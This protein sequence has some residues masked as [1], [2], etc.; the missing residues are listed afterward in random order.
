MDCDRPVYGGPF[1]DV[2]GGIEIRMKGETASTAEKDGLGFP[3]PAGD[4]PAAAAFLGGVPGIDGPHRNAPQLRLVFD[5][6][7]QLPEGPFSEPLPLRL[8]NRDP[9]ALQILDG[10][11][12]SGVFGHGDDPFGDQVVD[13]PF[14]SGLAPR[15]AL[16][17]PFGRLCAPPLKRGLDL[18]GAL[19]H[20]IDRLS[21]EDSPI[22]GRHNV[23]DAE[24]HAQEA[25]D[26]LDPLLGHL[27]A[28]IEKPLSISVDEI[29]LSL[30]EGQ[31]PWVVAE[32]GDLEPSPHGPQTGDPFSRLIPQDPGIVADR[33]EEPEAPNPLSI[34]LVRVGDLGNGADH[35][36]GGKPPAP[37]RRM[38]GLPVDLELVKDL[39]REGVFR[40][41]V[42]RPVTFLQGFKERLLLIGIGQQ[43]DLKGQSHGREPISII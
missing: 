14:E 32:K 20:R 25:L 39:I 18:C 26:R 33:P 31:G 11:R 15:E 1:C 40:D 9:K 34:K 28:L 37:S 41:R 23:L 21:V 6:A 5:E 43:F 7:S 4:M 22:G 35:G 2:S 13:V 16:E 12:P 19:S 24:I 36:L 10:D 38:I 29:P 17:M 30:D 3:V 42:G 8:A 27:D